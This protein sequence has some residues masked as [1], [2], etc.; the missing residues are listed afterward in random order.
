[1]QAQS[2]ISSRS[3]FSH[4]RGRVVTVVGVAWRLFYMFRLAP[5]FRGSEFPLPSERPE[6]TRRGRNL[7]ARD[8]KEPGERKGLLRARARGREGGGVRGCCCCRPRTCTAGGSGLMKGERTRSPSF[9][10]PRDGDRRM[11]NGG[12]GGRWWKA[13][14]KEGGRGVRG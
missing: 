3:H 6:I 11:E 5:E 4:L 7:R 13:P 9:S 12:G 2:S 14:T 8:R 1:M 10:L